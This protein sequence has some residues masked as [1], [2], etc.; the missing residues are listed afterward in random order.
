MSCTKNIYI[1]TLTQK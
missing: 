1:Q